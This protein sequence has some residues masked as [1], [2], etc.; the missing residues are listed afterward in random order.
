MMIE[1][2]NDDLIQTIK[3]Y[4]LL[5][6]I[7]DDQNL[8]NNGGIKTRTCHKEEYEKVYSIQRRTPMTAV[9]VC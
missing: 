2:K 3:I 4:L 5:N 8:R 1:F 7:G 9:T 6:K